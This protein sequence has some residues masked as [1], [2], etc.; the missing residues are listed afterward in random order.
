MPPEEEA[1]GRARPVGLTIL[2]C[3]S[4]FGYCVGVDGGSNQ[5]DGLVRR[6]LTSRTFT[7]G[8]LVEV[9]VDRGHDAEEV[10]GAIARVQAELAAEKQRPSHRL[11]QDRATRASRL[12]RTGVFVLVAGLASVVF[13]GGSVLFLLFVVVIGG[14]LIGAGYRG[15]RA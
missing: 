7:P 5:L 2:S 1:D 9:L 12:I 3:W 11:A 15:L 14:A 6:M 10:G 4:V 8:E 13:S